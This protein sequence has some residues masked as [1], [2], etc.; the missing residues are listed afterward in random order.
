MERGSIAKRHPA[1]NTQCTQKSRKLLCPIPRRARSCQMLHTVAAINAAWCR[2]LRWASSPHASDSAS[3]AKFTKLAASAESLTAHGRAQSAP[4]WRFTCISLIL[5]AS[6]LRYPLHPPCVRSLLCYCAN[7]GACPVW[8]AIGLCRG[9]LSRTNARRV[10][11]QRN[12]DTKKSATFDQILPWK[13]YIFA[14]LRNLP[15]ILTLE[16]L[17]EFLKTYFRKHSTVYELSGQLTSEADHQLELSRQLISA[18]VYK[19]NCLDNW[20]R[21]LAIIWNC[22]DNNFWVLSINSSC[23]DNCWL[24]LSIKWNRLNIDLGWFQLLLSINY[25]CLEDWS[26][27][28]AI[29]WNCSQIFLQRLSINVSLDKACWCPDHWIL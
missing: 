15:K 23:P 12:S 17:S 21:R 26:R 3:C 25:N 4:Y 28:L 22:P 24:V 13:K 9:V 7:T 29:N 8:G 1:W 16:D 14:F 20:F 2:S 27:Q 19:L 10:V 5:R 18:T 11:G 6:C